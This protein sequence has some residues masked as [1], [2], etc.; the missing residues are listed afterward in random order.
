M[1]HPGHLG[2]Y[3]KTKSMTKRKEEEEEIQVKAQKI[4]LKKL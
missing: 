2:Q 4:F 1:L 3:E